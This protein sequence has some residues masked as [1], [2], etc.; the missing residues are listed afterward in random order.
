M[1]SD[2]ADLVPDPIFGPQR[3][4]EAR[5]SP[6]VDFQAGGRVVEALLGVDPIGLVVLIEP[7]DPRE[8]EVADVVGVVDDAH[9]VGFEEGHPVAMP[10]YHSAIRGRTRGVRHV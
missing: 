4:V 9:R 3:I 2:Y 8:F 10:G 1:P 7:M 5:G 6:V